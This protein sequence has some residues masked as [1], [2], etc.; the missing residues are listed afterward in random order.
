MG[1][2]GARAWRVSTPQGLTD[3]RVTRNH[4]DFRSEVLAHRTAVH[5]LGP[6]QG[7]RLTAFEP[8]TRT[9]LVTHPRGRPVDDEAALHL[10][11][12]IHQDAG[13]LLA[14]LHD[15]VEQ[16]P[17]VRAQSARHLG[18]YTQRVL[19]LLDRIGTWLSVEEVENVRRSAA[20]LQQQ[21]NELPV[22]FCHG[23]FGTGSWRW[24]IQRQTLSVTNV[25][26]AK[27]L[28]AICDF[29]R[30][31]SLWAAHK[32]LAESFLTAYGRQLDDA[33]QLL[34]SDAALLTAVE[35]VHHALV[36]RDGDALSA[37][38]AV[39]RDT[40]RQRSSIDR[41]EDWS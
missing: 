20:R 8:R 5:R 14:V 21:G 28:P 39:L 31:A 9:L 11:P 10:L 29:A 34:L 15:S 6:N 22:A 32:H 38:G 23:T 41:R 19:Y 35:D 12:R 18:Q 40:V 26:R 17:D 3:I 27:V 13:R 36:L 33:E 37:A 30:S 1:L 16:V 7:P 24:N 25:E 4:L 2:S